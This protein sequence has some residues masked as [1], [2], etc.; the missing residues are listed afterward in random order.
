MI[1]LPHI[2]IYRSF[3]NHVQAEAQFVFNQFIKVADSNYTKPWYEGVID[4][5]EVSVSNNIY[6]ILTI[7]CLLFWE[8]V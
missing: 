6:V 1:I 7:R 5:S 3:V 8:Q 2:L 4:T